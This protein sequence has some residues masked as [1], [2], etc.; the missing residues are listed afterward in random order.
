LVLDLLN[1]REQQVKTA[2][3]QLPL[4]R[5]HFFAMPPER[6]RSSIVAKES[7]AFALQLPN[8]SA[9]CEIQFQS[10]RSSPCMPAQQHKCYSHGKMLRGSIK[11]L[12]ALVLRQLAWRQCVAKDGQKV[13]EN[14]KQA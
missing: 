14:A 10:V 8:A 3:L 6:V 5:L 2:S 12:P 4:L 11:E 9:D 1:W 7:S 13:S